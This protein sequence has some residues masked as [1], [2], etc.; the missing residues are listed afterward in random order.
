ML[1]RPNKAETA[2]HGCHCPSDT[3][4]AVRMPDHKLVFECVTCFHCLKAVTF[5]VDCVKCGPVP[6]KIQSNPHPMGSWKLNDPPL[7]KGSKT[8][9]P[10]PLSSSPP[11]PILFDQTLKKLQR[12]RA[13]NI[14]HWLPEENSGSI[15][16]WKKCVC[17]CANRSWEKFDF[18]AS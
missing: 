18:W 8:D 17:F 6:I 16:V 10:H 13:R 11:S 14:I 5:V 2:V 12:P 4:M 15:S 7:T 3:C 1:M 9:D